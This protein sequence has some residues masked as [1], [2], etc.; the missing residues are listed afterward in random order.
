MDI[1]YRS[2]T[3]YD[4]LNAKS[5]LGLFE[6][7]LGPRILVSKTAPYYP[8]GSILAG[9]NTNLSEPWVQ[10]FNVLITAGIYYDF[11]GHAMTDELVR[12]GMSFELTY[13][14]AKINFNGLEIPPALGIRVGFFF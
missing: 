9:Y 8:T 5:N 10:G 14:T 4:S 3:L 6:L 2:I 12:N 11:S 13:R 1:D 7:Y